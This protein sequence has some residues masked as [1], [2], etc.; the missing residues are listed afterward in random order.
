MLL[1]LVALCCLV[2]ALALVLGAIGS[3][4]RGLE[5]WR[6]RR[7]RAADLGREAGVVEVRGRAR[8]DAKTGP[9]MAPLTGRPCV[10]FTVLVERAAPRDGKKRDEDPDFL[11]F[12]AAAPFVVDDGSGQVPVDLTRARVPVTGFDV[13]VRRPLE[14]LTNPLEKLLAARLH[15]PGGL[16]CMNREVAATEAVLLEGAEVSVIARRSGND[17]LPLHVTTGRVK[18]VALQL[19]VQAAIALTVGGALLGV[20]QWIR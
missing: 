14:R 4:R 20:W 12:M 18:G 6:S 3:V 8:A 9:I 15:K 17:V 2:C 11:T 19:F 16:W 10:T 13:V 1:K 5:L 7:V